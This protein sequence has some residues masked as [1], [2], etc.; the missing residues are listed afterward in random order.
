[1]GDATNTES[2]PSNTSLASH[3]AMAA[4]EGESRKE[5]TSEPKPDVEAGN[6]QPVPEGPPPA[7][8]ENK[9][10]TLVRTPSL[11]FN[12]LEY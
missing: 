4:G 10:V 2:P 7:K 11:L 6:T 9:N 3:P 8:A 1:M 5:A 12:S